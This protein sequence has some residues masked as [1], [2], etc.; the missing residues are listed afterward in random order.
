MIYPIIL[1][2]ARYN[3]LWILVLISI[4]LIAPNVSGT[5]VIDNLTSEGGSTYQYYIDS[6]H[7]N[8]SNGISFEQGEDFE[9]KVGMKIMNMASNVNNF[10]DILIYVRLENNEGLLVD[11]SIF[12]GKLFEN[13]DKADALFQFDA[14]Q[15]EYIDADSTIKYYTNFNIFV[16]S[17][18]REDVSLQTDPSTDDK[19]NFFSEVD[20]FP[21]SNDEL[22]TSVEGALDERL[23]VSEPVITTTIITTEHPPDPEVFPYTTLVVIVLLGII[24]G[25]IFLASKKSV[26]KQDHGLIS[27]KMNAKDPI[28]SNQPTMKV[29]RQNTVPT[30]CP[31]C[32]TLNVEN[33]VF[34]IECGVHLT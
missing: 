11:S 2:V 32:G 19:W 33:S 27:N 12:I 15:F 10:H 4:N 28:Q 21:V 26:S 23:D 9:I 24:G 3:Y 5:L 34:C 6:D 1:S 30:L 22:I 17:T 20:I 29:S 16:G 31:S 7:I 13:L 14:A 18:F 8:P 25:A